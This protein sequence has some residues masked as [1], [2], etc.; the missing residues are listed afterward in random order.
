MASD[1][2]SPSHALTPPRQ[3]FVRRYLDPADRLGE[4]L[5]GLIMVLTFTLGAGLIVEEGREATAE[6]LLGI[7]GC[8]AAWGIIDGA[9]YMM[10]CMFDRSLK[11]RL[12]HAIQQ[13]PNEE[14]ALAVVARELDDRLEPLTSPEERR[15]LYKTVLGKL[16]H[17]EP[18]PTR[19]EKD[20]VYGA[21][22]SFL[23][24][25]LS[26]IPAVVPFLLFGDRFVALRVSN[27]LLI[28][29]LF[30]IGYRWARVTH[31]NPWV[32]GTILVVLGLG[33]VAIAMAL[34][35]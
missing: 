27:L 10:T 35:G 30:M 7:L 31:S 23:L 18:E 9:M 33:L 8:N 15:H 28:A 12:L 16:Q 14:D 13:A 25:F 17:L 11:A 26:T 3:S 4:V 21:I 34:G 19:L 24:V 29:M 1:P 32:L 22:A 20:D 5:F 6:M 2:P